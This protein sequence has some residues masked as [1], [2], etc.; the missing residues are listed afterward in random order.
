MEAARVGVSP[1]AVVGTPT[2]AAARAADPDTG[3]VAAVAEARD[4]ETSMSETRD[5]LERYFHWPPGD[6]TSDGRT[7]H[8]DLGAVVTQYG[9]K[10]DGLTGDVNDDGRV[11]FFD[12]GI[13]STHYG[14]S[15][16]RVYLADQRVTNR[17]PN[18]HD[19]L[20]EVLVLIRGWEA[21]SGFRPIQRIVADVLRH[22]DENPRLHCCIVDWEI[23]ASATEAE[24]EAIWSDFAVRMDAI[25]DA[26]GWPVGAFGQCPTVPGWRADLWAELMRPVSQVV[27]Q[28]AYAVTG[29][30]QAAWNAKVD[31]AVRAARGH[32]RPLMLFLWPLVAGSSRITP[33][34]PAVFAQRVEHCLSKDHADLIALW[35]EP[36][37]T[38]RSD[39]PKWVDRW[40]LQLAAYEAAGL[41]V[42]E[43]LGVQHG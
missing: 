41:P 5:I 40:R 37:E 26:T 20:P 36:R 16:F 12:L 34:P 7:D 18:L 43:W 33:E 38:W 25:R 1:A 28:D 39:P 6:A 10:G 35:G 14:Q 23:P 9:Q 8:N 15:A 2:R 27:A 22:R 24:Q 32:D 21:M 31:R 3:G 30:S 42:P 29:M 13:V 4:D 19:G 11:D 17:P